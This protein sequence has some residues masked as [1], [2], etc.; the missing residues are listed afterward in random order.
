MPELQIIHSKRF[1]KEFEKLLKKYRSLN[2]DLEFLK[3]FIR[4]TPF[5]DGSAHW[6]TLKKS[7]AKV[8][9]KKRMMCRSLKG[10]SFRIIYYYD[11]KKIELELIEIYFK[12]AKESEDKKRIN[13]IWIRKQ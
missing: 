7:G 13:E 1:Q 3:K 11:G 5:G 2:D 12:G 8:V 9:M 6:N 4:E 10:S